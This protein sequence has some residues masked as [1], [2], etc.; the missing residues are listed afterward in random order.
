MALVLTIFGATGRQGGSVI[1]NILA[2]PRLSKQYKIR[3]VTRDTTKPAAGA[4]RSQG[5]DII[6]VG[7]DISTSV[8][9]DVA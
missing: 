3:A 4:L 6:Q 7:N 2:H 1:T 8:H 5:C 9:W